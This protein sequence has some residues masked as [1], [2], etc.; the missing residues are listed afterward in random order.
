MYAV[1]SGLSD[2]GNSGFDIAMIFE[3]RVYREAM[4]ASDLSYFQIEEMETDLYIGI[5]PQAVNP[6]FIK[7]IHEEVIK[8]R[9]AIL[10]YEKRNPG[11]VHSLI[12]VRQRGAAAPIVSEM[13]EAAHKA[14]IGP[15]GAVA[16]AMAR[17]IGKI[18]SLNSTEV[19][20]ENGGDIFLQSDKTRRIALYTNN[21]HFKNLGLKIK[22]YWKALGICTSSGTMGH[23]L[24]FGKADSVTVISENPALA[25]AAATALGNRIEKM[26][27]IEKGLEWA[28][29]IPG[30]LGALIIIED[31]MGAWGRIELC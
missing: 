4:K 7:M 27:D 19:I 29:N 12:P 25:D 26:E 16:G 14:G 23:S 9:S 13:I 24:S 28:K 22:P 31:K 30:V 18:I 10:D 17:Q 20:I 3:E 1:C 2:A 21:E 5:E 11:F 6:A 8:Q 15:M